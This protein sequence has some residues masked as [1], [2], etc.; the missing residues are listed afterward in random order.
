MEN[1]TGK[2][3]AATPSEATGEDSSLPDPTLAAR[4]FLAGCIVVALIVAVA[5]NAA[6]LAVD[7]AVPRMPD[8][9]FPGIIIAAGTKPL[10]DFIS[11]LQNKNTGSSTTVS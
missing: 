2:I 11:G 1:S 10:H 6:G 4:A 7:I 5:A 9:F 8:I 3:T